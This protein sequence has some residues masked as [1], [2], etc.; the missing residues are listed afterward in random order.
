[1]ADHGLGRL[2]AGCRCLRRFDLRRVLHDAGL[3]VVRRLKRP[4]DSVLPTLGLLDVARL[5]TFDSQTRDCAVAALR[6]SS[7]IELIAARDSDCLQVFAGDQ[8]ARVRRRQGPDGT[9]QYAY[10]PGDGDPLHLR[11]AVEALRAAGHTDGKGFA[12]AR[13]WLEATADS[14]FPAAPQ[15]LWEGVFSI[16]REQPDVVLSLN[17]RCFCG[18]GLLSKFVRMQ[19]THGG[20][21]QR[22]AAT[23]VMATTR[24]LPSP[25]DLREAG[26][27]LREE[28]G[29]QVRGRR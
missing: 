28:F 2:P 11:S 19:G 25:L 23:F 20:L 4:G 6:R 13:A 1:M 16:S 24:P 26:R 5:H 29:W 8:T 14:R 9:A 3:R 10:E 12:P 18:S 17:E 15:R 22:V 27:L 7:E 21:H